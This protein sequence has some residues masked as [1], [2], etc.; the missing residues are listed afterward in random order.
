MCGTQSRPKEGGKRVGSGI[1]RV[2]EVSEQ[3][4]GKGAQ[5]AARDEAGLGVRARGSRHARRAGLGWAEKA[6][7]GVDCELWGCGGRRA[8]LP[9]A[10]A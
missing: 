5:A 6:G 7:L 4:R 1:T 8:S 9:Q 10:C 3:S 2:G